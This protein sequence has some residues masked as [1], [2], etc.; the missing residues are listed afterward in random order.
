MKPKGD[1]MRYAI[2][3][4]ALLVFPLTALA[5]PG[6]SAVT[7]TKD[8]VTVSFVTGLS[9]GSDEVGPLAGGALSAGINPWLSLEGSG[10]FA[11]RGPGVTAVYALASAVFNMLPASSRVVPFATIG[12]GLYHSNFD[13][14]D[15]EMFGRLGV[16]VDSMMEFAE[17]YQ[18]WLRIYETT[19]ERLVQIPLPRQ[20]PQFYANRIGIMLSENGRWGRRSF[21]DPATSV[22]GGAM[23]RLSEKVVLRPDARAILIF[24]EGDTYAVGLV[25]L[26]IGFRF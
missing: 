23:I 16:A 2:A 19:G 6:A 1:T 26:G 21:T 15:R 10:G 14:S 7:S 25:N 12:G 17:G 5:Q 11:D 8:A 13:L 22:G 3:G 18:A 9:V 24:N 20:V 4:L